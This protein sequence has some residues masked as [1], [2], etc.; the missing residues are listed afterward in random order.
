MGC[1]A[2]P[3]L[4]LA[5]TMDARLSTECSTVNGWITETD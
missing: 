3:D 4:L 5:N 2:A 1:T